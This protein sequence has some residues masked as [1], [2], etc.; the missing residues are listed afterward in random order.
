VGNHRYSFFAP[1]SQRQ[2]AAPLWGIIG[3]LSSHRRRS[4]KLP[5]PCGESLVFFLRTA[6]AG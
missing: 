1:P 6:A 5:L 2:A 3:I 4:G